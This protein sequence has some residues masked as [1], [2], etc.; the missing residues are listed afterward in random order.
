MKLP[1]SAAGEVDRIHREGKVFTTEYENDGILVEAAL[2]REM[3][4]RYRDYIL[5]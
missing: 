1:Y 4:G 2:S 5:S 3:Q